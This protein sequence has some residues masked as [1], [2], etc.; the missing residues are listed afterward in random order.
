MGRLVYISDDESQEVSV[1]VSDFATADEFVE[2]VSNLM[3]GMGY[4]PTT[5]MRALN[6]ED[7]LDVIRSICMENQDV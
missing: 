4:F 7:S 3:Y 2:G 5:V 1:K 6:L